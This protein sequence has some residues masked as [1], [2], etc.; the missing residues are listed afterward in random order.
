VVAPYSLVTNR[1]EGG[2]WVTYLLLV[3]FELLEHGVEVGI[4]W[5]FG[6]SL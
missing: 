3:L 4:F 1:V 5:S 2:V 6:E